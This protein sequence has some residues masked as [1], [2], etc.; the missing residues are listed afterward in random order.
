MRMIGRGTT[1]LMKL[2][3]TNIASGGPQDQKKGNGLAA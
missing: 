3:E 2:V 1:P